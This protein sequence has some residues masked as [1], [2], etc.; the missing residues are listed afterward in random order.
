VLKDNPEK[1]EATYG[2]L[3]PVMVK[4][5]QEL[6]IKNEKLEKENE[7]LRLEKDRQISELNTKLSK[8]EEAQTILVKEL[9]QIKSAQQDFK[10]KN[11]F[12]ENSN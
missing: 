9:Q 5:I 7:E 3:L 6:S 12:T 8:Y 4:A 11:A 10:I 2:N 1:W